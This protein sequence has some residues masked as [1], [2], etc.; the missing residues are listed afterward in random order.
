[1]WKIPNSTT[2]FLF[3]LLPLLRHYAHNQPAACVC[4]PTYCRK[5][6]QLQS[7]TDT[8]GL[9]VCI[10][11]S[12]TESLQC[13]KLD[14]SSAFLKP[15]LGKPPWRPCRSKSPE[16][17]AASTPIQPPCMTPQ[18]SFIPVNNVRARVQQQSRYSQKPGV[19][20]VVNPPDQKGWDTI[21]PV[22]VKNQFAP[23]S[24]D[25]G[26]VQRV[27]LVD[28]L[29]QQDKSSQMNQFV[30]VRGADTATRQKF[31]QEGRQ[32][33]VHDCEQYSTSS[34]SSYQWTRLHTL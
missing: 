3:P 6:S 19:A 33:L 11:S 5:Q 13:S 14:C 23:L 31:K 12:A 25:S 34:P 10:L 29:R 2:Q 1:M 20:N 4:I 16:K 7:L 22:I 24:L 9:S 26:W 17:L 28:E 21:F 18:Y 27:R 8:R 32:K 15:G 30:H